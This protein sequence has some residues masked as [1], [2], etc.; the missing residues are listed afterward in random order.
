M[1]DECLGYKSRKLLCASISK[2]VSD[3]LP[4]QHSPFA[5]ALLEALR[6]TGRTNGYVTF[7]DLAQPLKKLNPIPLTGDFGSSEPGSDFFFVH[8][9][10]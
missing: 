5:N 9:T 4:G 2:S 8:S 7:W 3:G 1:L 10:Q 6:T